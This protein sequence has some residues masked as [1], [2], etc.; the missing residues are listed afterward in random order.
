MEETLHDAHLTP[1]GLV[2]IMISELRSSSMPRTCPRFWPPTTPACDS[3]Q[4]FA[5][6]ASASELTVFEAAIFC[7]LRGKKMKI[8]IAAPSGL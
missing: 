6:P 3:S 4:A 8:R 5:A 7:G 1:F 2:K